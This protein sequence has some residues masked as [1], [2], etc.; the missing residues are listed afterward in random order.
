MLIGVGVIFVLA[1]VIWLT[2]NA[3]YSVLAVVIL[4]V[5]LNRFFFPSRFQLDDDG[6]TARYPLGRS[7]L[8]W[9]DVRRFVHG[10]DGAFLATR[11]VSG[12]Y[13]RR[14]VHLLFGSGDAG[15]DAVVPQIL[16]HQPDAG[17]PAWA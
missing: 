15:R 10:P 8:E 9:S 1:A 4:V 12:R 14:G 7:R 3:M 11:A 16:S 2:T 13:D 17:E 6:I 5:A